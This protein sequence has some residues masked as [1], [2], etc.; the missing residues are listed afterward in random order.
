MKKHRLLV[1]QWLGHRYRGL[2]LL[3]WVLLLVLAVYDF[4]VRPIFDDTVWPMAWVA[5]GASLILWFYYGLL[6]RRATVTVQPR[7]LLVQGPLR[8]IR[9]SYSRITAVTSTQ[10]VRH[11]AP[12]QYKG[13]ER[14]MLEALGG[15][16]CL[17]IELK[18]YP[19]QYQQRRFWFS[20]FL[21]SDIR[22]G[23]LLVVEDWMALSRQL[24][25]ARSQWH[26]SNKASRQG[27]KRS[28]AARVLDD[29]R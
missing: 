14:I 1:Y 27:D 9:I 15:Q 25:V 5:L 24:E 6:I 17:H 4:N 11:H 13:P 21:F 26:E 29:R 16:T 22:P 10:L 28:L 18:S 8:S 2:L 23:L 12:K 7:V 19:K 3:L 20:R